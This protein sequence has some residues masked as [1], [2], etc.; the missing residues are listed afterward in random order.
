MKKTKPKYQ[1]GDKVVV[2]FGGVKE[3]ERYGEIVEVIEDPRSV[4]GKHFDD[5]GPMYVIRKTGGFKDDPWGENPEFVAFEDEVELADGPMNESDDDLEG[6][7]TNKY[8]V[9]YHAYKL[10]LADGTEDVIDVGYE[11]EWGDIQECFEGEE[12]D[13][14]AD[15]CGSDEE[16]KVG[17]GNDVDGHVE[18]MKVEDDESDMVWEVGTKNTPYK[19]ATE[20]VWCYVDNYSS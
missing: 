7:E 11:E 17:L 5:D 10:Y 4:P 1:V 18:I 12:G 9:P 13:E 19:W 2:S 20:K 15:I 6:E 8:G 16:D 3:M 14:D